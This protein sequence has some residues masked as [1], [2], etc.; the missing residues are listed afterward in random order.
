[1]Q[2]SSTT[3]LNKHVV[4]FACLSRCSWK[5]VNII[6]DITQKHFD[7]LSHLYTNDHVICRHIAVTYI[8][9]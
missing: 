5:N 1:M 6:S 7:P 8:N 4:T 9:T 2:L 3:L